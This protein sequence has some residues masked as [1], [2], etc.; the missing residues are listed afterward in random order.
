MF[1]WGLHLEDMV[2]CL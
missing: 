2:T 1:S